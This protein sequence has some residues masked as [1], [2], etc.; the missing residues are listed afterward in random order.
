MCGFVP[1][2]IP[3]FLRTCNVTLGFHSWLETL[4][5]FALV[6]NPRLRSR[7]FSSRFQFSTPFTKL[8]ERG[9]N[10]EYEDVL[11]NQTDVTSITRSQIG[12]AFK[13][14]KEFHVITLQAFVDVCLP[15]DFTIVDFNCGTCTCIHPFL[16]VLDSKFILQFDLFLKNLFY[17][18]YME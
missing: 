18:S 7:Q 1:L 5:A 3:T 14:T 6:A 16:I 11:Y 15:L 8:V 12:Q 4:Q 17:Y 13:T 2:H 9:I 10:L